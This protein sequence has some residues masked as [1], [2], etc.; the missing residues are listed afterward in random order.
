MKAMRR[1]A[2]SLLPWAGI[3]G[4]GAGWFVSQ[5]VGTI[6]I[7]DNCALGDWLFF[8]LLGLLGILLVAGGGILSYRL[9]RRGE[10]ETEPRRF[11]GL[12]GALLAGLLSFPLILH[13]IPV[14]I[15]P[16]C[17]G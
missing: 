16:R 7:Q 13:T 2:E 15:I 8:A 3:L 12:L 1:A 11:L 17:V 6:A 5:Q 10:S 14:F 4:A 9:W